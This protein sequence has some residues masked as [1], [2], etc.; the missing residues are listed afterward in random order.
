[1]WESQ[2]YEQ[3][4]KWSNGGRNASVIIMIKYLNLSQ[5]TDRLFELYNIE[6]Y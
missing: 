2:T 4:D 5:Q 1:M 3:I 6:R